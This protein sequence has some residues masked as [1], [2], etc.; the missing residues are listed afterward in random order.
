MTNDKIIYCAKANNS[1]SFFASQIQFIDQTGDTGAT[2]HVII[3]TGINGTAT[4]I[5]VPITFATDKESVVLKN[6]AQAIAAPF[7]A[8][9]GFIDLLNDVDGVATIGTIVFDVDASS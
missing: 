7:A 9:G 1:M 8:D 5:N 2:I 6:L 3:P 4:S